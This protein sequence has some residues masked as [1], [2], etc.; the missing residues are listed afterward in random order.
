MF[1]WIAGFKV[2]GK[3]ICED[4]GKWMSN[5]ENGDAGDFWKAERNIRQMQAGAKKRRVDALGEFADGMSQ[6]RV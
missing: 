3:S 6:N 2:E 4:E 1:G 5:D